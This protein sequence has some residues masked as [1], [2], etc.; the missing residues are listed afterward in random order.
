MLLV[1]TLKNTCA[2]LNYSRRFE[3]IKEKKK[4]SHIIVAGIFSAFLKDFH[5]MATEKALKRENPTKE[6]KSKQVNVDTEKCKVP[7][8]QTPQ[9]TFSLHVRGPKWIKNRDNSE[10]KLKELN[11]RIIKVRHPRQK[12]ADYVFA[13]FSNAK[14]RDEAYKE[15]LPLKDVFVQPARKHNSEFVEKRKA[16]VQEKREAKIRL[17]ALMKNI[18]KNEQREKPRERP[19]KLCNQIVILNLPKTTTQIELNEHFDDVVDTKVNLDKNPKRK[20]SKAILT[21]A[22]PKEA[23]NASKKE[24][25]M[26]GTKLKIQLHM[27]VFE[28]KKLKRTEE[29]KKRK[30]TES[31]KKEDTE[32]E[33]E[34]KAEEEI[35]PNAKRPHVLAPC[36]AEKKSVQTV[37]KT[38]VKIAA[39]KTSPAKKVWKKK[40]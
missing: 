7:L 15:L 1:Q 33:T 24:I 32:E 4:H 12:S 18:S 31:E 39:K 36:T 16:K 23:I 5:P 17:A 13:D 34:K 29:A 14:E 27:N 8:G 38:L 37:K 35:E 19:K 25:T 11:A 20:H 22:T 2:H 3:I 26:H 40:V 10:A 9:E 30:L 6:V 21:L 28:I